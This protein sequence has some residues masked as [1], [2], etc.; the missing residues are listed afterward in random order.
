MKMMKSL[1]VALATAA[2]LALSGCGG[3][4]EQGQ[5]GVRTQRGKIDPQLV[6][7]GFYTSIVS[8]VTTYTGKETTVELNG[9]QPQAKDRMTVQD[10]EAT[11]FYQANVNAL[12]TFQAT[13]AGQSAKVSGDG[14]VRP[15]YIM[16][17]GMARSA[18]MSEVAKFDAD[19]LN[20]NREALEKGI[21]SDLQAK[22]E[23]KAP[24]TFTI[25]G[26][27]IRN[28]VN[29]QSV[30][31]SIRDNVTAANK[32][33]TATKLV[34]VKEQEAIANE[35]LANSFT[36]EFLQ[37]EYNMALQACAESSKCT[38][39]IDGSNSG[40]VLNLGKGQ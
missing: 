1:C 6:T 15:G 23:A 40:K 13:F 37:H 31:Q 12:P 21:K 5:V 18:I 34:Q 2:V 33:A 17:T 25:T 30:Q 16:I 3:V 19:Q 26:V 38:L 35:K 7:P 36:P 27:V 10:F 8:E 9:L 32:L 22:L 11:V 4:M 14:F 39:I 24:G 28:I 20:V 29:D